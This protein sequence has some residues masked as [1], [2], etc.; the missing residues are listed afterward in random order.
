MKSIVRIVL[1]L[2]F[3]SSCLFINMRKNTNTVDY[4][5]NLLQDKTDNLPKELININRILPQS[6]TNQQETNLFSF[7]E[8]LNKSK[9]IS[10]KTNQN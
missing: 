1:S 4:L 10:R 6:I 5:N 8:K 9:N 2:Y 3:I 7:K